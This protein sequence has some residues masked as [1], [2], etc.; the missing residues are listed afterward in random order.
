MIIA[1]LSRL[2]Q[3]VKEKEFRPQLELAQRNAMK[4]TAMIHQLIDFE[5]VENNVNS[6]LML[7]RVD[8]V[9]LAH[10]V[11]CGFEEGMFRDKEIIARF[12][13]NVKSCYQQ[14]DELKME[15]AMA[16]LL[17]NAGKYTPQGGCVTMK[18]MV[19][20]D[21]LCVVVQDTGI[22]IPA[23][24]LP[25]VSQRF[26]QSSATKGKKEG[27]GIGLYMVRAY[28]ELHG[29]T[30]D[31]T[32]E[33]GKGTLVILTIPT[34]ENAIPMPKT[35]EL[36]ADSE[37]L[38]VVVLVDDNADVI[39]FMTSILKPYCRCLPASNGK[40]G[41][42]RCMEESPSLVITDMMMPEMDGMEMCQQ[43][44]RHVPTS[45]IPIIMLTAKNDKDTE[46]ESIKMSIDVF[47]A[48]PF[49]ANILLLRAQQLVKKNL[50]IEKKERIQTISE[51]KAIEAVSE[52]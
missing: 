51:P 28:T 32:S 36:P 17:S 26:F 46:L 30:M 20:D 47:L 4:L 29:G 49:D 33:E 44:R 8:F 14:V 3:E 31:I 6:T 42:K 16:N 24:D 11:F 41:L 48:K 21:N 23:K 37:S 5:R 10:K 34:K 9:A 52:D 2:L 40:E 43:L 38:P 22:G 18:L 45:T 13:T 19:T 35:P 1:P 50:Q 15:S 25:Y 7:G 12:E 27:T 39:T